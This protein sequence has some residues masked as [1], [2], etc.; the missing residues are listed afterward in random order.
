MTHSNTAFLLF[1]VCIY[2]N[3]K[4]LFKLLLSQLPYHLLSIPM[5]LH[6][7]QQ[8]ISSY[9]LTISVGLK[10]A[11]SLAWQESFLSQLRHLLLGRCFKQRQ[12]PC[13]CIALHTQCTVHF[14]LTSLDFPGFST[15]QSYWGYFLMVG[16]FSKSSSPP[17]TPTTI[18][19]FLLLLFSMDF[20]LKQQ[21]SFC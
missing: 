10:L 7:T 3:V 18:L 4:P 6:C 21:S 8:P 11:S 19:K 5:F 1:T 2:L 13:G 9:A 17:R 14:H 16:C 20:F 12:P 15:V